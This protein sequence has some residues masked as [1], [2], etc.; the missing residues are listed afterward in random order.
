MS[1]PSQSAQHELT[2]SDLNLLHSRALLIIGSSVPR[3]HV[4]EVKRCLMTSIL[5]TARMTFVTSRYRGSNWDEDL[6]RIATRTTR[7]TGMTTFATAL[8]I[9]ATARSILGMCFARFERRHVRVTG[10]VLP[11]SGGDLTAWRLLTNPRDTVSILWRWCAFRGRVCPDSGAVRQRDPSGRVSSGAQG[12][13][14]LAD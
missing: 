4:S 9:R 10:W 8:T 1:S 5:V 12:C 6:A 2:S 13:R 3:G 7:A 14:V 11:S